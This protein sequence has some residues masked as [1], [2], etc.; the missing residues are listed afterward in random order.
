[1]KA[2]LAAYYAVIS[3]M[4]EQIG[5]MMDALRATGQEQNT[6]IVFT[7]DQGLAIGSHGLLGKQN[8]YE[9]TIGVPL[10]FAGPGIPQ[11]H[12]IAAQCYLRDLFPTFCDLAGVPVPAPVEGRSLLPVLN[13]LVR[14]I[15]PEVY[16]YWHI[17]SG[18][19]AKMAEGG[20]NAE[21]PIER[22]VRTDRWKLI[23]YS[24]LQ[25]YQLFDLASDPHELKDLSTTPEFQGIK[26]ELQR[27]LREW[28]DPR[29]AP[30]NKGADARKS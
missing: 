5:R 26:Q 22:M 8:M 25:R 30:Y 21:L 12:R 17:S 2:E 27:K 16:A 7:T 13:G 29:V 20:V 19:A 11:N 10:I 24:H 3:H 6:L 9:H 28:F 18:R 14:E 1:V 15:Y 23:Y 4:D